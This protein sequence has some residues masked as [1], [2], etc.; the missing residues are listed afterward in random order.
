METGFSNHGPG[1]LDGVG[2]RF[3]SMRRDCMC[4]GGG[5]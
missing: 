2:G 4:L 3:C 5:E 1:E